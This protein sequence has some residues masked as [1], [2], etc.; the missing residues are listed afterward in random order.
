M[1]KKS[2][3]LIFS[4]LLSV[5]L[6]NSC[7]NNPN[8]NKEI[9]K[10]DNATL[11]QEWFPYSGYAGEVYALNETAKK[12]N[13]KLTL[14]SGSDNIDPIKL[15]LSKEYDFGVASADRILKANEKGA[16]LVVVGVINYKSPTC[17]ITPKEKNIVKPKDFEHNK[18][19]ILTGTNTEMIY[20]VLKNKMKINESFIEE[21]EIPFDL[22]T[23]I[24]GEY[25][26]RPAFFYDETVSLEKQKIEYNVIKPED[27]GVK[28][29]G[30]VYFTTSDLIKNNPEKVQ[31]FV[32][33]IKEGWELAIANPKK[34]IKYLK[35][36]DAEIDTER[37]LMSLNKGLEY[38]KG[39]NNKVLY[40]SIESW[41]EMAKSMHSINELKNTDIEKSINLKFIK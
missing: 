14:T 3:K 21:V 25:D 27:Y 7:D 9:I 18:V 30:T 39:E 31:K 35:M 8:K 41:I 23:F 34:A 20:K 32:S 16:E 29:I 26:V 15:V 13:L 28:F 4:L 1:N 19:G 12:H 6:L 5:L 17:F 10:A 37:E 36:F 38:F 2:I 22:S 11:I 40:T 24:T 33:S